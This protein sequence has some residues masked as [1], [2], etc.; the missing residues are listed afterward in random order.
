MSSREILSLDGKNVSKIRVF[1][2]FCKAS[3]KPIGVDMP[4]SIILYLYKYPC[5]MLEEALILR[6]RIS[7]GIII[8]IILQ[9]DSGSTYFTYT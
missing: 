6:F 9:F 7:L 3:C 8:G 5:N 2:S 1:V 4:Y